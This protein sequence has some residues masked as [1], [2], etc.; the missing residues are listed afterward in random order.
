MVRKTLLILAVATL[1]APG[2]LASQAPGQMVDR[3]QS[4][5][6]AGSVEDMLQVYAPDAVFEDVNQRHHFQGVEQLR[7]FLSALVGMHHEIDLRETRRVVRGD[8][9]VVQY[10]YA[11]ILNGAA[12]GQS[13]GK[14]GCPDLAYTLP[15]TSWFQVKGGRITHQI[16]FIDLATFQE[17]RQQLLAAAA[18]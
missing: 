4:A 16:D 6:R 8:T 1:A 7:A 5:Y 13:V 17:L 2:V 9:V 14:E 11:G 3:F 12:L 15:A 18:P 10:E